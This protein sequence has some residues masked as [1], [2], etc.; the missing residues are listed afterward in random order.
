MNDFHQN[1]HFE[2]VQGDDYLGVS[3]LTVNGLGVSWPAAFTS[4]RFVCYQEAPSG[5]GASLDIA[6]EIETVDGAQVVR[7]PIP[8]ANSLALSA[9]VRA[10]AFELRALVDTSKVR[11]LARGR[12][13]VLRGVV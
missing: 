6:C 2:I 3:R 5:C 12:I 8:R 1:L 11:T 7:I 4:P 13:T 10:Y 9:G